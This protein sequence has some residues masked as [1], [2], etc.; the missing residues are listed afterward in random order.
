MT[1]KVLKRKNYMHAS[2]NK[3]LFFFTLQIYCW[4]VV[5]HVAIEAEGSG[6]WAPCL[7]YNGRNVTMRLQSFAVAAIR[8]FRTTVRLSSQD[9]D[10]IQALFLL[11]C[12]PSASKAKFSTLAV[13]LP[14]PE[15]VMDSVS[16]SRLGDASKPSSA[17]SEANEGK[18]Q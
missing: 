15:K 3:L 10:F 1:P 13:S 16:K 9:K 5:G 8:K 14:P 4:P 7:L 6:N 18:I 17:A 11:F 12:S 2:S